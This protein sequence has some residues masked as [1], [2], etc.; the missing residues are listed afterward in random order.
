MVDQKT[1]NDG[2]LL[3]NRYINVNILLSSCLLINTLLCFCSHNKSNTSEIVHDE[4]LILDLTA[5][6]AETDKYKDNNQYLKALE[7]EWSLAAAAASSESKEMVAETSTIISK[8]SS[9]DFGVT[10]SQKTCKLQES[11]KQVKTLSTGSTCTTGSTTTAFVDPLSVMPNTP[12]SCT[13][14]QTDITTSVEKDLHQF[15]YK[16]IIFSQSHNEE[17]ISDMQDRVEALFQ[18]GLQNL[19][20]RN[21]QFLIKVL[22]ILLDRPQ[23]DNRTA[24]CIREKY[25]AVLMFYIKCHLKTCVALPEEFLPVLHLSTLLQQYNIQQDLP[26]KEIL[27]VHESLKHLY[28]PEIEDECNYLLRAI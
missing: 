27:Q 5:T 13:I 2:P 1:P 18:A 8:T 26:V 3:I 17:S 21:F 28:T 4:V 20:H 11:L 16:F 25:R 6:Q 7:E 12:M 15:L 19:S 22:I 9:T 14:M 10:T 24:T 23:A